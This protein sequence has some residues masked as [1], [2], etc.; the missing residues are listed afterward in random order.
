MTDK[1]ILQTSLGWKDE[2]NKDL[3]KVER[4]KE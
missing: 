4:L 2:W 1:E 3:E